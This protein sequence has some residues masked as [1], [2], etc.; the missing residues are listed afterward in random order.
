MNE[1]YTFALFVESFLDVIRSKTDL[2]IQQQTSY[3]LVKT[4]D[5]NFLHLIFCESRLHHRFNQIPANSLS[6][7]RGCHD[8]VTDGA[9]F[10]RFA[11]VK[12]GETGH[13][14]IQERYS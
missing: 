13:R 1:R 4:G 7:G 8:D 10:P 14:T 9:F 2:G 5:L 6:A 11:N 12:I 3:V